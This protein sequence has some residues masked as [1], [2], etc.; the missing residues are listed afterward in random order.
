MSTTHQIIQEYVNMG[1]S[2]R[3]D[4]YMQHPRLRQE[5]LDIDKNEID[6][7][8]ESLSNSYVSSKSK[9]TI[10]PSFF[11]DLINFVKSIVVKPNKYRP[12]DVMVK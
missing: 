4:L 2:E 10:L 6:A 9:Q 7:A 5:F 1:F 8:L 3:L 11:Q 12:L